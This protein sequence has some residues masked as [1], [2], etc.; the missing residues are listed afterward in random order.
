MSTD[1]VAAVDLSVVVPLH[2]EEE[3]VVLLQP[4]IEEACAS[5]GRPF[6]IILVDD[7]STDRTWERMRELTC[8][9]GELILVALR[10]NCGQTPAMAAGF[11][12]ARGEIVVAMDGDLQNDPA[13][14]PAM[15][16]KCSEGYELVCGWRKNRQ[17]KLWTRKIPSRCANWLIRRVTGVGVHDYGC[18]LKAYRG[19]LVRNLRLYSDMHRFLPFVAQKI[20]ARVGEIVVRHHARR[21]GKTKYGLSR[22][23]KV[24]ADLVSLKMLIHH[25]RRIFRWFCLLALLPLLLAAAAFVATALAEPVNRT[26]LFG[27]GLVLATLGLFVVFLGLVGDLVVTG[28]PAE[29]E[30]LRLLEPQGGRTPA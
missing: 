6:E 9:A 4:K 18:S 19:D 7:G 26:V 16:A 17:D 12:I 28:D 10:G 24:L 25:H 14:I 13:D 11:E 5:T 3:S 8:S 29:Y 1:A 23:W 21:Y 22:T 20:G 2:N 30:E 15:L 27:S